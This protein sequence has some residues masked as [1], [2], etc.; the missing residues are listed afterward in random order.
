MLGLP[1][2]SLFPIHPSPYA[3]FKLPSSPRSAQPHSTR[4][5]P[6]ASILASL[7]HTFLASP[8]PGSLFIAAS[9]QQVPPEF[10][11]HIACLSFNLL[12]FVSSRPA[13]HRTGTKV[14][15]FPCLPLPQHL[16][17]WFSTLPDPQCI[18]RLRDSLCK[19]SLSLAIPS[20]DYTSHLN[21][22]LAASTSSRCCWAVEGMSYSRAAGLPSPRDD[23]V[24]GGGRD[25]TSGCG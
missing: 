5:N 22:P 16:Y 25:N 21:F 20:Q 15:S 1:S 7:R 13:W 2:S 19:S 8:C 9:T 10:V 17:Y 18:V 11:F 6:P 24:S 23:W 12:R 14:I 4:L 3:L